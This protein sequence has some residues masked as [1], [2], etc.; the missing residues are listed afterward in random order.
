MMAGP[1][2]AGTRVGEERLPPMTQSAAWQAL[3]GQA[4]GNGAGGGTDDGPRILDALL[5]KAARLGLVVGRLETHRVHVHAT[6]RVLDSDWRSTRVA[7]R[8]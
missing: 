6:R 7:E 8:S 5:G 2:G 1:C 4:A 3:L